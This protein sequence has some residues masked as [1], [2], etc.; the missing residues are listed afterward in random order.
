MKLPAVL[1]HIVINVRFDM[2]RAETVFSDLGFTLTPRGRHSMGSV[3]HLM[4]FDHDYLELIGIAEADAEKRPEVSRAPLGLNG[5]V[6][7]TD[8]ADQTFARLEE[9]GMAGNPPN[10]FSRPLVLDDGSRH[11][12]R[13]RTVTVPTSAFPAGRLYFCE[14]Q[15]PELLWRQ[16]WQSHANG[17]S[18]FSELMTVCNDPAN[19]AEQLSSLLGLDAEGAGSDTQEIMFANGFRLSF[20]TIGAYSDRFG[21]LAVSAGDRDAYF[22]ALGLRCRNADALTAALESCGDAVSVSQAQ[23]S[24]SVALPSFDTLIRFDF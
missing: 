15:T 12:A 7:K 14:H 13:F 2:D 3:N 23:S 16:E 1:D 19:L 17:V 5:L 20:L 6:F 10:A 22:G 11:E 24:V 18:A 8:N 9:F 4:M 21:D